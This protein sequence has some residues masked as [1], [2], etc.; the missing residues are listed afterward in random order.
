M[1][2]VSRRHNIETMM[3]S[4]T[5]MTVTMRTTAMTMMETTTASM[6]RR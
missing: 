6:Q 5:M 3:T 1:D 2:A 4:A